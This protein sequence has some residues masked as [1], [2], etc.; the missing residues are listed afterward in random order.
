MPIIHVH[1]RAV[2]SSAFARGRDEL[3][4]LHHIEHP[5]AHRA[6]IHAQRATDI[7]R[8]TL[9]KFKTR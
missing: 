2:Q 4:R 5:A 7:T 3:N 9:E 6:G 8:N 1:R